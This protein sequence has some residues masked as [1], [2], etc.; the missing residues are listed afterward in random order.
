MYK[1]STALYPFVAAEPNPDADLV[2]ETSVPVDADDHVDDELEHTE[3]VWIVGPRVGSVEELEH[4]A[5]TKNTVDSHE[6]E[7]D[8][9]V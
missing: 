3:D 9:E 7:V 1:I 6:R 4:P 8:A 5:D 2:V